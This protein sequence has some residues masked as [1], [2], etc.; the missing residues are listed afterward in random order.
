MS[1]QQDLDRREA[2]ARLLALF[3]A[4]REALP[5][6]DASAGFMPRL[7]ERIEAR[8]SFAYGFKRLAQG[9]ITAAAVASLA[10]GVY[11]ARPPRR[12]SP[13][14]THSYLELLAAG[15]NHDN[16]ADAEIVQ[17]VEGRTR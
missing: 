1:H 5:D 9:F 17:A 11:L 14:Y 12:L 13:F 2:D 6:P 16:L 4:Y 10:M 15:Q 7:W 8:Q 3:G